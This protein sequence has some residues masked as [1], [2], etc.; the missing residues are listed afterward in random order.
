MV[1]ALLEAV[2]FPERITTP[3][4]LAQLAAG[5]ATPEQQL[6]LAEQLQSSPAVVAQLEAT[7]QTLR[8]LTEIENDASPGTRLRLVREAVNREQ[9]AAADGLGQDE[10]RGSI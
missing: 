2:G 10:H 6:R 8:S 9:F 4:Q 1:A 7:R 3:E 5:L